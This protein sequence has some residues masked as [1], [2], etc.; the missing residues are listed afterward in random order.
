M[1]ADIDIDMTSTIGQV[2]K[3]SFTP[4]LETKFTNPLLVT[5]NGNSADPQI[6]TIRLIKNTD[7]SYS[8]ALTT[9]ILGQA[10]M[11]CP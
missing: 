10:K 11:P 8:F 2:I 7:A 4:V 5:I 3:V 9:F 6:T 1:T